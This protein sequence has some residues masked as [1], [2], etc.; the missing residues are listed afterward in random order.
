MGCGKAVSKAISWFFNE[1][2]KGIILEDDCL[3]SRSFFS[4][5]EELLEKYNDNENIY[6]ISGNNFLNNRVGNASYYFSAYG[7]IWGW[8][9]WRRAWHNYDFY[10]KSFQDVEFIKDLQYYFETK[11]EINYWYNIFKIMKENPIDTWDYQWQ[12]TQ[13][14]MHGLNIMPNINLVSNIGFNQGGTHTFKEID[15]ISNRLLHEF[16]EIQHPTS[17]SINR[18]AD[19]YLF[20]IAYLNKRNKRNL[21]SPLFAILKSFKN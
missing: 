10:L 13:W 16:K 8:A 20:K 18:Y 2:E 12:F 3:P 4:F 17:I 21:F 11:K 6:V 1:V 19:Q 9:S 15:G 14:K 7:P 5:C